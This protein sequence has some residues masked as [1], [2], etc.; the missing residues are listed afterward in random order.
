MNSAACGKHLRCCREVSE[1]ATSSEWR[2]RAELE[3]GETEDIIGYSSRVCAFV[4]QVIIA[5]APLSGFESITGKP[6]RGGSSS[7][8]PCRVEYY[9]CT[10][11]SA[12]NFRKYLQPLN[13]CAA[14]EWVTRHDVQTYTRVNRCCW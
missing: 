3:N 6:L 1:N 8:E 9:T 14:A 11:R 5:P 7:S 2:G 12:G 13:L 10:L 4:G